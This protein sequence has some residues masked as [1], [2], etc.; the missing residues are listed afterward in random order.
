MDYGNGIVMTEGFVSYQ[1]ATTL[2]NWIDNN[3]NKFSVYE[4]QNNPRRH[5]LRFGKDQVFWD[6]SPHEIYGVEEIE[7]MVRGYFQKVVDE[8]ARIYR[9]HK[10]LYVNSFWLAKQEAGAMVKPHHD[11]SSS[12]N[13]QFTHSII[14]YLNANQVGGELEFPE[15][16]VTIKPPGG[17][18]VSF[19]AQGLEL[20]HEVKEITQ[21][22]YTMLFWLTDDPRYQ[23][24]FHSDVCKDVR[25]AH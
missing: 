12:T 9:H 6:T 18:M 23:V 5:A 15:L 7:P 24:G 25:E 21:D 22:R 16:G 20:I 1:D 11:A 17:S 8:I 2:M 19:V 3:L 4:F 13:P 10:K 14:C